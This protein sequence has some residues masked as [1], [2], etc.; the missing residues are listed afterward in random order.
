LQAHTLK[1]A[2]TL[3]ALGIKD[4]ELV[5]T[6]LPPYLDWPV[7]LA[8]QIIGAVSYS[9][10]ANSNFDSC[11]EPKWLI[12]AT[13]QP[14]FSTGKTILVNQDFAEKVNSADSL[15][16]IEIANDPNK[17]FRLSSTSGTSGEV[18]YLSFT[19][20][21]MLLRAENPT[22]V[23]FLDSSRFLN[24]FPLGASQS[25]K[26]ALNSLIA[27][28]TYFTASPKDE[29]V[30]SIILGKNVKTIIGSPNHIS[31]FLT[32]LEGKKI[33]L[34]S[35]HKIIISG[36][37]PSPRILSRIRGQ[38]QSLIY[39]S[40]GSAETGSISICD[41][42]TENSPGLLL[43]PNSFVE[44]LDE[45]GR[46]IDA[47]EVGVL[48]Y[49][50]PH[51]ANSYF[52]NPQ[53][54]EEYFKDGYFYSGDMGYKTKDGR[55]FITGRSNEVINLG[56][57]KINPEQVDEI[58]VM[59]EGVI[60]VAAFAIEDET[61]IPK[62]AIA[63]VID[64]EFNEEKFRESMKFKFQSAKVEKIFRVKAIPR[65]P[66]GKI[67]RRELSQKFGNLE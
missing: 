30:G 20:N 60:D 19:E 23:V 10:P 56:G 54:T 16:K 57:V 45:C 51:A 62:L 64:S 36:S 41:V 35:T 46:L 15:E 29:I 25:Y 3:R 42:T 65:N 59:Q 44:V 39:N 18:K 6:I 66:N 55:L 14:K 11:A 53:A 22:S 48:R 52:N 5:C 27:G 12:S 49:K 67:L 40:H 31:T 26:W 47:E 32:T 61:G 33:Q 1:I 2:T 58:A 37:A 8:L 7:T 34:D 13:E 63:V 50:I 38:H 21:Q 24:L 9:K 28:K 43:L 4:G 17:I